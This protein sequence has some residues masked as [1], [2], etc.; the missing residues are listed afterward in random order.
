MTALDP[1]PYPDAGGLGVLPGLEVVAGQLAPLITV[2][3][4]GQA[5]RRAGIQ[6]SRPAWKN[7]PDGDDHPVL[8]AASRK[9]SLTGGPVTAGPPD[10]RHGR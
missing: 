3:R 1:F 4:A 8:L 6:I 7:L 9:G 10:P 5:R 2:L